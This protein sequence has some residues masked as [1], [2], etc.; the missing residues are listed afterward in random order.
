MSFKAYVKNFYE[1]QDMCP[2]QHVL[3]HSRPFA[4][5]ASMGYDPAGPDWTY[6]YFSTCEI[7]YGGAALIAN[8]GPADHVFYILEGEGYSMINGKRYAYQEGDIMWTPGNADHE[9]YPG[10]TANLKFLVTLCPRGFKPSEP[11]IKNVNDAKVTKMDGFTMFTLADEEITGSASQEFH[12]V[13]LYPGAKLTLD[14]PKSDVI[15][16]MYNGKCVATVD[17]DK[18]EM[19]RAEDAVVIPMGA[20]WE[21][22][23]VTEQVIRFAVSLSPCR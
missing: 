19:N 12:I 20:K 5:A 11:Y 16:Y 17:G 6:Q 18:L 13:D 3:A 10:G 8:H 15:A 22:E 7:D 23:N 2:V 21:I 9:M 4:N 14:T 1:M